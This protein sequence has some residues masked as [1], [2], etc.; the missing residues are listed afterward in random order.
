MLPNAI[1]AI[2][3]LFEEEH[4]AKVDVSNAISL[5]S[6]DYHARKLSTDQLTAE[7]IRFRETLKALHPQVSEMS[8]LC[9]SLQTLEKE[10]NDHNLKLLGV[11]KEKSASIERECGSSLT[12]VT[13]KI[14][15][16]EADI[17]SKDAENEEL[18]TKLEQFR[19]HL[20]LR[21]EKQR[22]E[23]RTRE[24]AAKLEAAKLAQK[25]YADEQDKMKRARCKSKI[26]HTQETVLQLQEQLRMYDAKFAEFESTLLRTAEVMAQ[27]DER[28][29]A[30]KSAVQ[31]LRG[32]NGDLKARAA[33]ADVALIAAL[34]GKKAAEERL[35]AVRAAV[36]SAE[37]HCRAVQAKRQ[38]E[39]VASK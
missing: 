9:R 31:V 22:N 18:R 8:E 11:E 38:K 13:T 21:R 33:H 27:L 17:D 1:E 4:K 25:S 5:K 34:D 39:A 15:A 29:A 16:E 32:T 37:K 36:L 6:K 23:E 2:R 20:E 24:L 28:E 3:N 7:T 30:L 10:K 35:A 12:S 14:A 19:A 26:A